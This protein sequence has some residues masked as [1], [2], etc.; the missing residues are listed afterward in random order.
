MYISS[1]FK[2]KLKEINLLL[3]TSQHLLKWITWVFPS[4]V[5]DAARS[6]QNG[7]EKVK[8]NRSHVCLASLHLYILL[9]DQ[10]WCPPQTRT[11]T[12]TPHLYN[13]IC[14]F[15]VFYRHFSLLDSDMRC[16]IFTGH[17]AEVA[18]IWFPVLLSLN[19]QQFIPSYTDSSLFDCFVKGSAI[20]AQTKMQRGLWMSHDFK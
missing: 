6:Q 12:H 13:H 19:K 5:F 17:V 16:K 1:S 2:Y 8:D 11:H 18:G 14:Y 4:L 7:Q 20:S 3:K 10:S 9:A 15:L